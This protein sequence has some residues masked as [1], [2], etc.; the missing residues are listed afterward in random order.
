MNS[1]LEQAEQRAVIKWANS[2]G[3]LR[4]PHLTMDHPDGLKF[5]LW[6]VPNEGKRKGRTGAG[7]RSAGMLRGVPDLFLPVS[8]DGFLGLHIEMKKVDPPGV[9]KPPQK[10]VIKWLNNNG[11]LAI[12]CYGADEAIKAIKEY[13]G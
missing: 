6:S 7:L 12:V 13:L 2:N 5:P 11:H 4:W 3:C 10:A 1:P 9:V 8:R